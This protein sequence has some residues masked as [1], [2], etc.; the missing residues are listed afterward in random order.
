MSACHLPTLMICKTFLMTPWCAMIVTCPVIPYPHIAILPLPKQYFCFPNSPKTINFF[1]V[2]FFQTVF[3][4]LRA[5]SW[6]Y[7]NL[8][9][10]SSSPEY[11][12]PGLNH[13]N[14]SPN[15]FRL[16]QNFSNREIKVLHIISWNWISKNLNFWLL[17]VFCSNN[18]GYLKIK[19]VHKPQI[20]QVAMSVVDESKKVKIKHGQNFGQE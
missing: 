18:C 19:I 10:P 1:K 15:T 7:S 2:I 14:A 11:I 4:L 6:K 8:V 20:L 9:F 17:N 12:R 13:F 16:F 5:M 3:F